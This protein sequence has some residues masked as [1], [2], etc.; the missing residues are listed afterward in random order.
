MCGY[1]FTVFVSVF[2]LLPT[3][4]YHIIEMGGTTA[5]A[6]LFLGA[7]TFSSALSAPWTG[8]LA[9]RIG[10]R[11]VL[12]VVS[13]ILAGFCASYAWIPDYHVLLAIVFVHGVFWSGLLSASSAY[14]TATIPPDRRAQG[15]G[16]WGAD[17]SSRRLRS[18]CRSSFPHRE[19]ARLV[20]TLFLKSRPSTSPWLRSRGGCRTMS[21]C[22]KPR[23]T[24]RR[25]CRRAKAS[26]GTFLTRDLPQPRVVRLRRLGELLGAVRGCGTHFTAPR[27]HSQLLM[28]VTILSSRVLLGHRARSHRSPSACCCRACC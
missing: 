26:S 14:M 17:V 15:L 25:I 12:I 16:Y 8:P 10:H 5:A 23:R 18:P 11:R 13:V 21:P 22:I 1:S 6:G 9:D 3:A 4:P 2:Q 19:P 27:C 24:G 7:L 20:R 28:A